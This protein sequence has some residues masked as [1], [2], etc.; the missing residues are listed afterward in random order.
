MNGIL[1]SRYGSVR[2]QT[3]VT[4]LGFII[5]G[6][7]IGTVAFAALRLMP[8]YLNYMKVVGVVNGVLG[9]FDG[10]NPTRAVIRRS[11]SR[12]FDVESVSVIGWRDVTITAIDGGFEVAAVY[13]HPAPFISNI[14][15]LVHF[16]KTVVVRR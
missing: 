13:D 10:Q 2:R 14:S 8:V 6:V 11:I 5:L 7:F 3:G 15:F 4:T 16:D 9:E 1:R 12:R